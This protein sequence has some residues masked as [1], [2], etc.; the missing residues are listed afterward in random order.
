VYS[1]SLG[2]ASPFLEK[3]HLVWRTC[4]A[5]LCWAWVLSKEYGKS[6]ISWTTSSPDIWWGI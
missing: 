2:L 5:W 3:W 4:V 1:T 6:N